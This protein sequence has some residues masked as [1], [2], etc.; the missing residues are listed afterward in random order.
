EEAKR[1][2]EE[3]ARRKAAE[4]DLQRQLEQEQQE[5][6]ARRV[7][8]VVDQYS[9]MIQQRVKRYWLRPANV[10]SGLQCTVQVSLLPGGDVKNVKIVK[11]SGNA[12]F[13]R[14]AESAVYK[15]APLPQPSDPKAAAALR[16]FQFIFKP[17]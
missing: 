17:E 15:A 2:A 11:S 8:G 5:R 9:L 12:V 16:D 3:E 10:Q 4:S 13:D 7:K 6:E 14:S 1:K